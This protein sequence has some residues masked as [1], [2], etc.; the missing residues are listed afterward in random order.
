VPGLIQADRIAGL[1]PRPHDGFQID[2]VGTTN[3]GK[4]DPS[5]FSIM[6]KLAI[7]GVMVRIFGGALEP[8]MAQ[9]HTEMPDP[10]R[11]EICGFTENIAKV[12]ATTD[13]FAYPV[14]E[15]SYGSSDIA[16]QEAMLAGLPVVVYADR[17]SSHFVENGKT[18]LVVSSAAQFTAAI[19]RLYCD[20][21]LR[22]ALGVA[23]R[24]YAKAEFASHKHAAR[25]AG[26]IED[27]AVAPKRPLFERR[28]MLSDLVKL[29]PAALFL[30]SQGWPEDEAADAV[31]AWATDADDRLNAFAETASDACYKV[32]GGIVHWRNH[33]PTDPLLR[34]WSGY[35]LQRSGRHEEAKNEFDAALRLGANARAVAR[36]AAG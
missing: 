23:A 19:E 36:L 31:T 12:F 26:V 5:I 32:E 22:C 30:V 3:S 1:V 29:T 27:A 16:L 18:G 35:W 6:S 14:A 24:K 21:A 20:P 2:Y 15:S 4:L 9:A 17:G 13:V 28:S 8:A 11:I 7:P 10:S 25:L 33:Q 34:S